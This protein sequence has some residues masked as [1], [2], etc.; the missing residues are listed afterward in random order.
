MTCD[1][2]ISCCP[3]INWVRGLYVE[4][5]H[6]IR[7]WFEKG[8]GLD[9]VICH[10]Y[11]KEPGKSGGKERKDLPIHK[12]RQKDRYELTKIKCLLPLDIYARLGKVT[13][14]ISP[15]LMSVCVCVLI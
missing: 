8:W 1:F 9:K 10:R 13:N 2:E 3:A 5:D 14:R 11:G 15:V 4:H 6:V 12:L 7:T